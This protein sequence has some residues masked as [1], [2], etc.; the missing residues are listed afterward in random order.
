MLSSNIADNEE[1]FRLY[2]SSLPPFSKRKDK[3]HEFPDA[4]IIKTVDKWCENQSTKMIFVT[5]DKDF[6]GYKSKRIIFKNDLTDL[7]N[8]I[9]EYY[10]SI[11]TNKILPQI[12]NRIKRFEGE[13]L[14]L[15][16]SRLDEKSCFYVEYMG[17]YNI[18]WLKP[19]F[20]DYKVTSI[21]SDYA[22][23]SYIVKLPVIISVNPS[24]T[25]FHRMFFSDNIK[26]KRIIKDVTIPCDF[27]FHFDRDSNIQ[28]KW[29]NN[30]E[31]FGFTLID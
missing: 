27:E 14:S 25:D 17:Y 28:L 19:H 15:I 22:D 6:N 12:S 30:N 9:S 5:Y 16:E 20:Y 11:Q 4:F 7:L 13:I 1:V 2:F 23:V 26:Q 18:K 21:K 8:D 24:V 31:P 10:D 3:K 29:I